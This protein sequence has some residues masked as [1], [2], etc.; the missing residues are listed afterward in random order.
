[1]LQKNPT[2]EE[3]NEELQATMLTNQATMLTNGVEQG[4]HL[5]NGTLNSLA[6]ELE[7]MSQA[8]LQQAFQEK[9]DENVRLKHY[10]DTILLNIVENY[11]Q[12]LEVKP[13][14]RK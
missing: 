9:E 12:L 3:Q 7:E 14:E 11:P 1:M 10:I 5:L 4:R 6:Q 8:Q 2:L 13:M